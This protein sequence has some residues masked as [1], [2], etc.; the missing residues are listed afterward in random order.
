[1]T[2]PRD[3]LKR[4]A[5][6]SLQCTP[7]TRASS[8]GRTISGGHSDTLGQAGALSLPK[9]RQYTAADHGERLY[10][11]VGRGDEP[12]A[13]ANGD[14]QHRRHVLVDDVDGVPTNAAATSISP[15]Q[16]NARNTA[17]PER[18]RWLSGR[19]SGLR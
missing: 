9:S 6:P 8:Q 3:T 15:N 2:Q 16:P 4:S 12:Q 18:V 17:R 19:G 7:R 5:R 13:E 11:D 10:E 14:R 1:M